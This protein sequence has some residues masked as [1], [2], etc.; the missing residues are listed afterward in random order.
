MTSSP[1]HHAGRGIVFAMLATLC[2]ASLDTT[3]QYVGKAAP[4]LMAIWVRFLVQ[5]LMMLGMLWPQRGRA[6]LVARRPG[7]QFL[8]GLIMVCCASGAY[9]AL[10]HVPVGEFTAI[11][12]LIPLM[13]T[14]LASLLLHERVN[15][16]NW[17]LVAGG[18]VGA[19]IVVRPKGDD[20]SVW[21]LLPLGLV[22]INA[23]Y[24]IVTS[25]M[26]RSEDAGTTHFY[27]GL[28]GLVLTS[29]ALPWVWKSMDTPVLW[30]LLVLMG[31]FASV[32]HYLLIRAFHHTPA[33][34]L[35]PYMYSQIAF[36]TLGGWVVFGHT[37]D[38][39]TLTGIG[40]ITLCGILG[41]RLRKA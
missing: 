28:V 24:Q 21:L 22:V 4:V 12:M 37:P 34:R 30:A 32:G 6:M 13:V 33:S 16:L 39:W 8:R 27:T 31:L 40:L 14:L 15:V 29:V 41:V 36:A 19:L 18:F 35:T 3:S 23:V 17:L 10:Q 2:F 20:F 25:H 38:A 9:I 5:T 26:V 1:A 7:W 11:M